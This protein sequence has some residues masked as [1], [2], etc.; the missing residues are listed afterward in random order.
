MFRSD[1]KQGLSLEDHLKKTITK[2]EQQKGRKDR[3]SI[4]LNGEFGFGIHQ[5]L[6]IDL[7]LFRGKSLSEEEITEIL[8]TEERASAKEKAFRWLSYRSHSQKEIAQKLQRAKFSQDTIEWT[9]AELN[10]LKF[11]DDEGFARMY[12]HDRLLK[13]PIGKRLLKR[14][15]QQKGI[16]PETADRV[17]EEAYSEKSEAELAETLL[18]KK[19]RAYARFEPQKARQKAANFLAQRGFGWDVISEALEK[20]KT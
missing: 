1:T 19:A 13:R 20:F 3:V 14:E 12:A 11:L 8:K 7:D 15:L 9:L 10:R 17:V 16:N 2:I 5:N 18:K 6:L 4:F